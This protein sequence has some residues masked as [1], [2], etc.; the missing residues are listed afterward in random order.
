MVTQ[1]LLLVL[2]ALVLLVAGCADAAEPTAAPSIAIESVTADGSS[3]EVVFVVEANGS[4]PT[5]SIDWGDSTGEPES[6]GQGRFLVTHEYFA[7]LAGAT[8][9]V[10]ATNGDGMVASD[11][12]RVQLEVP[13]TTTTVAE[14]TT[15]TEPETTTTV[16]ETTTTTVLETTTTSSTTTTT[17]QPPTTT[18]TQPPTTTTT[19]P[20]KTA[21]FNLA[22]STGWVA[23]KWGGGVNEAYWDE[24]WAGAKA[25]RHDDS[26]EDDGIRIVFP[27]PQDKYLFLV[28]DAIQLNFEFWASFDTTYTLDTDKSDGNA[29]RV[30]YE[31]TGKTWLGGAGESFSKR[32]DEDD[33]ASL[34]NSAQEFYGRWRLNSDE[35]RNDESIV[36]ELECEARGPGGAFVTSDSKCDV[37]IRI[38]SIKVLVTEVRQER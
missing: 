20:P 1:R 12:A 37:D 18:T 14:T 6:Q 16:S 10:Q 8:I 33:S 31:F 9:T 7:E 26:W 29:A 17:T 2:V 13:E 23:D 25:T 11:V 38:V 24:P 35:F 5:I 27:I 34:A 15:T 22:L 32:I 36:F 21:E 19:G 4:T 30:Y 28:E 3:V